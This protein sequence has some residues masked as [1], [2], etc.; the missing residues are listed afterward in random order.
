MIN[1]DQ[2]KKIKRLIEKAEELSERGRDLGDNETIELKSILESFQ[3]SASG[4]VCP[5][6]NG[7]GRVS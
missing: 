5:T 4:K 2:V 6:C 3:P 1:S 7:S